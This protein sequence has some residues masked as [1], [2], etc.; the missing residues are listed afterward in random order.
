MSTHRLP[1]AGWYVDPGE[2]HDYR[3]WNGAVWTAVVADEGL[4]TEDPLEPGSKPACFFDRPL[5]RDWLVWLSLL[6]LATV[7]V[8]PAI[9][10][11]A[12]GAG[13]SLDL[14][15]GLGIA[16]YWLVVATL[17]FLVRGVIRKVR[18][19]QGHL[20]RSPGS[21]TP[22]QGGAH[23]PEARSRGGCSWPSGS[24]SAPC[25][26]SPAALLPSCAPQDVP[27]GCPRLCEEI[28]DPTRWQPHWFP[29]AR[30]R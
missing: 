5:R 1:P 14:F 16:P 13:V 15:S 26:C 24:H 17:Y 20:Q 11:L 29:Q 27:E 10:G 25:S 12:S 28:A 18:A 9:A 22:H 8:G 6:W 21:L 7:L 30:Q 19:K 3:Y 2:F 4:V 23:R